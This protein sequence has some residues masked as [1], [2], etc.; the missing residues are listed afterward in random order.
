MLN[1]KTKSNQNQETELDEL[2]NFILSSGKSNLPLDKYYDEIL[3]NDRQTVDAKNVAKKLAPHNIPVLILGE[4]G[5]GKELFARLLHGNRKGNFIG[6][7]CGGIPDTLVEG[8][9]FGSVKGAFTGATNKEGFFEQAHNGTIFLD[10]IAELDRPL[11]SK[12]L[13]VI[14]EKKV[15]RLGADAEIPVNC[16]IISA[17]NH[18][19][20][21]LKS[22]NK[23]F[24]QD[25]YYRL[26]GAII[27]L[28]PLKLRGDD[29]QLIADKISGKLNYYLPPEN[30]WEGNI[31]ELLNYIEAS[32]ILG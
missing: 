4:T 30:N 28:K 14:Q 16:R 26:A 24:R 7:N 32:K 15:R 2:E 12:L 22:N 9:F 8:E 29:A 27:F 23:F 3:T 17:T 21:N 5:T 25:L 10:E 18:T 6:V 11:Q 1:L 20:E 19:V 13:R 31:R